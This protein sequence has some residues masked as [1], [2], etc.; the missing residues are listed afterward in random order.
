M[1][2]ECVF[3]LLARGHFSEQEGCSES[4][5]VIQRSIPAKTTIKLKYEEFVS[6]ALHSSQVMLCGFN[7]DV[8]WNVN[9][10]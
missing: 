8:E 10:I 5:L 3:I 7:K 6:F 9:C 1:I 4:S 2:L